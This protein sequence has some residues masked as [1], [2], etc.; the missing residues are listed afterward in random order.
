M[1]LSFSMATLARH[2]L[3]KKVDQLIP[4]MKGR[5]L[6]VGGE[7]KKSIEGWD[8]EKSV[9]QGVQ[10]EYLNLN[11]RYKPDIY[12]SADNIPVEDNQY[13]T[14]VS[15]ELLEHVKFPEKVLDEIVRVAKPGAKIILSIPY[16]Y[17]HHKNPNDFQRWSYEKLYMELEKRGAKVKSLEAR[18]GWFL[19]L[20]DVFTQ[21]LTG[22]GRGTFFGSTVVWLIAKF[23]NKLIF[24][25]SPLIFRF[26]SWISNPAITKSYFH[27]FTTGFIVM[28]E[29]GEIS[30]SI[31]E[32]DIPDCPDIFSKK[33]LKA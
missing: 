6:D 32:S 1:E 30:G 25:F 3:N 33:I 22:I 28:A 8:R 23:L 15:F 9:Q 26:D 13:D 21:G 19:V 20:M 4:F 11:K 7:K 14:V 10:W 5:G 24:I 2:S 18:G 27:R 31:D 12:A 29:N 17:R 16:M